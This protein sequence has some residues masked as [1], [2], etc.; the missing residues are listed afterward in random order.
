VVGGDGTLRLAINSLYAEKKFDTPIIAFPGGT[1]NSFYHALVDSGTVI[2]KDNFFKEIDAS[3]FQPFRPGLLGDKLFI[4]DVGVGTCEPL[5]G[6]INEKLRKNFNIGRL[7]PQLSALISWFSQI[8]KGYEDLPPFDLYSVSPFFGTKKMFSE[9]SLFDNLI[10]HVSVEAK[11]K[12]QALIKSFW[13]FFALGNGQLSLSRWLLNY[14]RRERFETAHPAKAIRIGG[15]T[16][17]EIIP[18]K[19]FVRRSE[20]PIFISAFSP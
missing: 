14:Q 19:S 6:V 20:Q 15:D 5:I 4:V 12:N 7:R 8:T 10:T 2:S 17:E 18:E 11:N 3:F 13:A 16:I 1:C 9:Q